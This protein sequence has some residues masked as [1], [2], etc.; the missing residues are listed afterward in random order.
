V[1]Q[2]SGGANKQTTFPSMNAA[3]VVCKME[4]FHHTEEERRLSPIA[5]VLGIQY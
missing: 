3:Q 4:H 5:P 2:N 1:N